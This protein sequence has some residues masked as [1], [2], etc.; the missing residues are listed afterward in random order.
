MEMMEVIEV[1]EVIL[2][3]TT[4]APCHV[5]D[6]ASDHLHHLHHLH[7]LQLLP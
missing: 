7:H 1:M 2:P 5:F 4:A 3:R 6:L